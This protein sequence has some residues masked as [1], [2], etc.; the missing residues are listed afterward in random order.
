[1]LGANPLT[2]IGW[3]ISELDILGFAPTEK[4]HG[5]PGN[6]RYIVE[7][8]DQGSI[9]VLQLKKALQ[10]RNIFR[11]NSATQCKDDVPVRRPLDSQ[12]G[13]SFRTAR[14]CS[15]ATSAPELNLL[16]MGAFAWSSRCRK[17]A[18]WRNLAQAVRLSYGC[19]EEDS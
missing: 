14:T 19:A 8:Q 3:A 17:F 4:F 10:L 5:I 2:N 12:H 1:L 15:N 16:K 7:I 11:L 9:R 18:I 13:F 6:Q